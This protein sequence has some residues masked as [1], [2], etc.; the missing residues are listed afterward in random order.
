[1][2]T[3]YQII[4]EKTRSLSLGAEPRHMP[5]T[6]YKS[7][8][9]SEYRELQIPVLCRVNMSGVLLRQLPEFCAL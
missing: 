6:A 2:L 3:Y 4:A 1:V 5:N 9:E 7:L 8:T